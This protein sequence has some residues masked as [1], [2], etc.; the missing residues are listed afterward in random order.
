MFELMIGLV[1]VPFVISGLIM[2]FSL[3]V[4]V[5]GLIG[6]IF[7]EFLKVVTNDTKE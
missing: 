3:A 2:L 6:L 7:V 5:A 1:L 4:W